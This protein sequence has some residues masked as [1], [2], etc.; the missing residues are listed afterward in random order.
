ML[1]GLLFLISLI[2]WPHKQ[3]CRLKSSF[4]VWIWLRMYWTQ[5]EELGGTSVIRISCYSIFIIQWYLWCYCNICIP[6]LSML[7]S[8][9]AYEAATD[10]KERGRENQWQ[11]WFD[12]HFKFSDD[13][14][15]SVNICKDW[16]TMTSISIHN[17]FI[18]GECYSRHVLF[19]YLCIDVKVPN[20]NLQILF[21]SDM[22]ANI[23]DY[24]FAIR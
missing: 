20:V 13:I 15:D 12:K 9:S 7:G 18:S 6:S 21:S 3:K 8:V 10:I 19:V 22:V 24:C 2:K 16:T 17:I 4:S 1:R 11:I 5:R 23:A 14:L